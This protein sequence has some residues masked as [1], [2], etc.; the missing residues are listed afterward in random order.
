M[1]VHPGATK[2]KL[3]PRAHAE[4][5]ATSACFNDIRYIDIAETV[6]GGETV[7]AKGTA[8]GAKQCREPSALRPEDLGVHVVG[9]IRWRFAL[10]ITF[11]PAAGA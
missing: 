1:P 8:T 9:M 7:G 6:A 10:K 2:L 5:C 11:R 3:T 4:A